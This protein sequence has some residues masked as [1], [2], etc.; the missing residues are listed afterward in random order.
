MFFSL[1]VEQVY[2]SYLDYD[3]GCKSWRVPFEKRWIRR[4]NNPQQLNPSLSPRLPRAAQ[5]N[6]SAK[7]L[8]Y[9]IKVG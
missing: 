7:Y 4:V 9:I 6:P 5:P 8:R 3:L 1:T 2:S